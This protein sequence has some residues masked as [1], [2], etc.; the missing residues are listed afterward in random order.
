[1]K[2]ISFQEITRKG[3]L[4]LGNTIQLIA[5]AEGLEAHANAVSIRL[6]EI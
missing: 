2:F 6:E 3:L 5:K 4:D 1:M